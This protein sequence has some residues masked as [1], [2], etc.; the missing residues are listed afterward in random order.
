MSL[1]VNQHARTTACSQQA[2]STFVRT[3][4]QP[5]YATGSRPSI[6]PVVIFKLQLIMFFEG[7]LSE[8]QLLRVAADRLSVRWYVAHDRYA[9]P[10]ERI[11]NDVQVQTSAILSCQY[12]HKNRGL[13]HFG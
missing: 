1:P 9:R 7:M 8:R 13:R 11:G 6:D 5:Y 3:L 10:F 4:V 12:V 2:G